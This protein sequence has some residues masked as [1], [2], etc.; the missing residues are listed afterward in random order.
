MKV[1]TDDFI[2]EFASRGYTLKDS[3]T[4]LNDFEQTVT[5]ILCR[6]DQIHLHGFMDIEP[7]IM[8]ARTMRNVSSKEITVVPE[9]G[10]VKITAGNRL[11][12]EVLLRFFK[13]K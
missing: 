6:G 2:R 5:D 7:R 8:H 12:K 9:H 13:G 10:N 11:K 1:L 4:I 3:K